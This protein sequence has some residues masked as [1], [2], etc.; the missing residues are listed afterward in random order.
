MQPDKNMQPRNTAAAGRLMEL[1]PELEVVLELTRASD[2][3]VVGAGLDLLGDQGEEGDEELVAHI[4]SL[5]EG[6]EDQDIL[7]NGHAALDKLD[8][9]GEHSLP[10]A[11]IEVPELSEVERIV[12]FRILTEAGELRVIANTELAPYTVHNFARLAE[13]DFFDGLAFH[14]VVPDFV[15]QDGCPRGDGWGGPAWSIPDELSW[16]PYDEGT[17]GMALSGPDTGGSQWF[18]TLSPQPHLEANYTVFGRL[19]VGKG[20]LQTVQQGTVIMDVVVERVR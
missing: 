14:R 12:S 15:I 6:A 18:L 11:G 4:L 19:D 2:P 9:E 20:T 8:P 5:L 10:K 13:Q 16:L 17:L 3:A 1:E 7:R